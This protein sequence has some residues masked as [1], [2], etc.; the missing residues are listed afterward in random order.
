MEGTLWNLEPGSYLIE[1]TP[2]E[3]P[4]GRYTME[5]T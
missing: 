5:V 2:W 1:D 3:S 4:H